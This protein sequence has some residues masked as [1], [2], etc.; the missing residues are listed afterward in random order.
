M[1][2]PLDPTK[3]PIFDRTL[4]YLKID[5]FS[6]NN[7]SYWCAILNFILLKHIFTFKTCIYSLALIKKGQAKVHSLVLARSR[8]PTPLTREEPAQLSYNF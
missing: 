2:W 4:L 6:Y 1:P 7:L 5:P 3:N 8:K